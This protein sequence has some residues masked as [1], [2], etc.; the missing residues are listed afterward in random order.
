VRELRLGD[1][2]VV[3]ALVEGSFDAGLT[4]YMVA[5]QHGWAQFLQVQLTHPESFPAHRLAV[6]ERQGQVV[7][8]ADYRVPAPRQGFLSYIC[9]DPAA[10]GA[11]IGRLLFE[12]LMRRH[13]PV[14]S[15]SLDVFADNAPAVALYTS[16]GFREV[17]RQVW[18]RAPVSAGS[19]PL[20]LEGLPASL[21]SLADYGFCEVSGE[22]D[23][24]PFRV[25]RMG[26]SVLRAF[27]ADD[28]DDADLVARLAATFPELREIFA[29]LPDDRRPRRPAESFN[30]AIRMTA[31]EPATG[32]S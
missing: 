2:A 23:G 20:P 4:P 31:G 6:V 10:R 14:D 9:V 16:M 3:A 32:K 28:Y 5:T 17:S 24:R 11:G 7:A 21:A 8:F 29:V 15:V 26:G 18:W 12:E 19:G 22:H 25:G 1:A 27:A 13:G 30:T